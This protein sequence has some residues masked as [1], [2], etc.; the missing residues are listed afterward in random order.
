MSAEAKIETVTNEETMVIVKLAA[1]YK[2][3]LAKE[4][5]DFKRA[6]QNIAFVESSTLWKQKRRAIQERWQNIVEKCSTP[7]KSTT[8]EE[9]KKKVR[10]TDENILLLSMCKKFGGTC[11]W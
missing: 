6:N 2:I 8:D 3:L 1:A 11:G 10:A 9:I 7:D 4:K 5:W